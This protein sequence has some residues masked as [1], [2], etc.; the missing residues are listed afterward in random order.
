VGE[1]GGNG[2]GRQDVGDCGALGQSAAIVS[3][4]NQVA[5]KSLEQLVLASYGSSLLLTTRP[6]VRRFC[7]YG[8]KPITGISQGAVARILPV[9]AGLA[10]ATR[11]P[12]G[13]PCRAGA[14]NPDGPTGIR[15]NPCPS[16]LI[17]SSEEARKELPFFTLQP[18]DLWRLSDRQKNLHFGL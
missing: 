3:N 8:P 12:A 10:T 11:H 17:D 2:A 1:K 6:G 14:L 16:L 7:Y 4:T 5:V 13:S 9:I 18:L 15:E